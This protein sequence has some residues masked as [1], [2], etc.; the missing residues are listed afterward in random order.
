MVCRLYFNC[1]PSTYLVSFDPCACILGSHHLSW[2]RSSL[3]SPPLP[4]SHSLSKL[5]NRRTLADSSKQRSRAC[6]TPASLYNGPTA[7]SQIG[8]RHS[9][10]MLQAFTL[11]NLTKLS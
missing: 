7:E 8:Q 5:E 3:I 9:A 10:Y 1:L 11:S 2:I 4:L 6:R